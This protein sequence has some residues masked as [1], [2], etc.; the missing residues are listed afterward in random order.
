MHAAQPKPSDSPAPADGCPLSTA[1]QTRNL[2]IFGA[3]VGLVYLGSAVLYVGLTQAALFEYFK[4]STTV[5]NLPTTAYFWMT[6]LP[7]LVA[8]RFNQLRHLKR[9]LVTCYL[10]T[11]ASGLVVAGTLL[12]PTPDWA[13]AAIEWMNGRLPETFQLPPHW[14]VPAVIL[15]G[16]MLGWLLGTVSVF[17]WE[18]IGRGVAELRRG[19]ALGLAFGVGPILAFIGALVSQLIITGSVE[20]PVLG[21]GSHMVFRKFQIEPFAYP[22][23]FAVMFGATAPMMGLAALLATLFVLPPAVDE[24]PRAPFMEGVF[25]GFGQFIGYRLILLAAIA[26]ILVSSGYSILGNITL[27]TKTVLNV[28]SAEYVGYQQ[29]LRFGFK[30]FGGL[31]LGWLLTRTHPKAGMLVTGGFCLASV[32]WLLVVAGEWIPGISGKWFLLSFGLMG[33]GE[34]FGVYYPNYILSCSA[35]GQMRRNMSFASMLN[36]PS[37]FAPVLF[38]QI[39]DQVHAATG[40]KATGY[41]ASFWTSVGILTSALLLV[42][43]I[44]PARPKPPDAKNEA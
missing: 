34:L 2:L 16:A 1:E 14:C 42:L 33:I 22:H 29:A 21:E 39:A 7:I 38:G 18:V 13:T 24:P 9:V 8:W 35:K 23:N 36:M 32:V 40:S 28:E 6:P 27:F 12:Y 41:V 44:L 19:R 11:A 3:N 10:T 26:L 5:A 17:Q 30:A 25:G 20:L 37:A 31:L 4:A 43:L 15:H